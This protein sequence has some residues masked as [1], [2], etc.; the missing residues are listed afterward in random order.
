[1]KEIMKS[2]ASSDIISLYGDCDSHNGQIIF[3]NASTAGF[4]NTRNNTII[5]KSFH[6]RWVALGFAE[7]KLFHSAFGYIG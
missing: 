7:N 4:D 6:R 1:M 3:N 5:L 2:I